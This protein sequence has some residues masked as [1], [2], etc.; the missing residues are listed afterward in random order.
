MKKLICNSMM[1][2]FCGCFL[3][4]GWMLW[5][6]QSEYAAA[7]DS[8]NELAQYIS[9]QEASLAESTPVEPADGPAK[10]V[11]TD[12]TVW[13][14]VD[15]GALQQI[16]SDV[17]AWIY[18]EGTNVNYPVVQGDDNNYYLRRLMDGTTNSSGTI[19]LDC[20]SQSDFSGKNSVIYGHN[21]RNGT[22]FRGI[23]R[24]KDQ[25]F[26]EE[27]PNAL[28]M[29]PNGN[30]KIHFFSGYVADLGES[31]WE[32][33]FTDDDYEKW[34]NEIGK[35]SCFLSQLTPGAMDRVVTLST[36]SYEFDNARFVLHGIIR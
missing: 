36:C 31:A 26:Y 2:V 11:Q 28:L 24:Y 8:H 23:M 10:V 33:Y 20:D 27:H 25:G 18:I 34:L 29:T 17:V 15:F 12:D 3:F 5:K 19:F 6:I 22:M 30:Y 9:I 4:C 13:L 14:E 21:M 16:N 32:L 35:K 7:S 1:I